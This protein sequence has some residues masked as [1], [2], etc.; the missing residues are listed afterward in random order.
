M[1]IF[2]IFDITGA[3][4][5]AQMLRLN[6]VASNLANSETMA[7]KPEDVYKSRHPVF[8]SIFNELTGDQG[9]VSVRVKK[10]MESDVAPV[11][12]YMPQHPQANAEGYVYSPGINAVEQMADMIAA[13]R[14]YQSN[15]EVMTTSKELLL[16]TL[17][18]GKG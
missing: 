9:A 13:S 16:R 3:G 11:A 1:S 2:K 8:E 12:H 6:T 15:V 14:S 4:M 10:I 7:G 5:N 17:Q 18:L